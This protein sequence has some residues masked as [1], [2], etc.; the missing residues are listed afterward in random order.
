MKHANSILI[1]IGIIVIAYVIL[2]FNPELSFSFLSPGTGASSNA[3]YYYNQTTQPPTSDSRAPSSMY[4]N[5][6]PNPVIMKHRVIG[7][8]TSDGYKYPIT[9]HAKHNGQG[10]EQTFGGL[11]DA[12]GRFII[13]QTIDLPGYW[14]F[15]ATAGSVSSNVASLTV[16]GISVVSERDHISKSMSPTCV[17]AVF[18]HYTGTVGIFAN[19][20]SHSVSIPLGTATVNS[21]G[22]TAVNVDFSRLANGDYELDA[23]TNGETATMYG[24][25][26]WVTVGR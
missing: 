22:Y 12:S 26:C 19:D 15:W 9:V 3:T 1:I 17:V 14:S 7:T 5:V 2:Q 10:K 13:T 23:H 11:L 25:T 20:P 8:V 21:G 24:G 16:G 18:S 4:A 6:E